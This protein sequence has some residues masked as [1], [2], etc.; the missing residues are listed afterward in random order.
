[1]RALVEVDAE[2]GSRDASVAD[3][4]RDD[5]ADRVDGDR[6]ADARARAR[7]A[8]DG[9]VHADEPPRAVEERPA[10]VAGVDGRVRLDHALDG[11]VAHRHDLAPEA[12][13]DARGERVVEAE[14]IADGEDVLS[15]EQ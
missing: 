6:E 11:A 10:R 7:G 8:V 1:E 13:D 14:G 4:L 3:E 15:D 12:A 9:G 5:A 2:A